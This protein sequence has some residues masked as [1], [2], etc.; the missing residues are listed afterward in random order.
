M[1]QLT[2]AEVRRHLQRAL[3]ADLIGPFDPREDGSGEEVL[4]LPP[5]RWYLTGFL[6][7]ERD[8]EAEV[9]VEGKEKEEL[10]V[11]DPTAD[12]GFASGSDEDSDD[13]EPGSEPE[14]KQKKLLPASIGFTVL[15]PPGPAG[16]TVRASVSFAEYVAE[17][18]EEEE[19]KRPKTVWRR[20]PRPVWTVDLPLD[21]RRIARGRELDGSGGVW[22]GGKLETLN[23]LG[24]STDL[25]LEPG[26]RALSLFMVNRRAPGERGRQDERFLFQ[27]RLEVEF[28]RGLVARPNRRDSGSGD[29]DEQEADLQFRER[30]EYAVGHGV[31]VEIPDQ[32]ES[33]QRARTCW[34]PCAEVPRVE[35]HE[36]PDL[37]TG[38]EQLAQLADGN[39]VRAALG[40]LPQA[41]GTWIA[42]R[43]LDELDTAARRRTRDRLMDGAE[44]ARRRI[45]AGIELLT[46]DPEVLDAFRIANRAM[47]LQARKSRPR[48]YSGDK[49]PRW[50]LFQLAFLLLSLPG[51]AG[52]DHPDRET[53]ELIFFPTGGGKTEAYLGV[54]AFLLALRRL[55]GGERPDGGLGVAV[56]LRYTL[57]LLTLDQLGRAA[58]LICAL[59]H[60]RRNGF[61]RLGDTRFAV[62]LWV[63]RGATAN[64]LTEVAQQILQ[65][66]SNPAKG[67]LSPFPLTHCP[68]CGTE[69]TRDSLTVEPSVS[70]PR[71]VVV[72]CDDFTCEYSAGRNPFGLPVLFVDEQVYRELPAFLVATVD[73]FAMLPWRGESGMLF[74]RVHTREG[75]RFSGPVDG[76]PRPGK[77]GKGAAPLPQG[78]RPPEL[79]VQDELHLISGPLGTMVGLY[80]TAIEALSTWTDAEGRRVRPKILASTAT[81]RRAREQIRALFGRERTAVFPPPGIDDS[82]TW[83]AH[84]VEGPETGRLYLG[85]AASGRAMKAIL[86]RVYVA[87][88]AAAH[89]AYDPGS[90]AKKEQAADVYMTL[91]GYFNSLREL[92]GMRRLVEDEVRTR[93]AQAEERRPLDEPDHLWFRN[94]DLKMEPAELT[95]RETT[96]KISATKARLRRVHRDEGHVDVLLASNMISVGVDIDR[97]GLMVV[98]GQPK[99]ASE[100][101]QATSRVGRQADRPG[102]VVTCFNLHRPRD[103]SHYERFA[104]FHQSFY[105][106]VEAASLTPFSGPALDRG[107]AGTLVAMTRLGEPALTPPGAVMNLGDH[108]EAAT[109]AVNRLAARAAL[110]PGLSGTDAAALAAALEGRGQGVLE[111]WE[112]LIASAREG[113]FQRSYSYFESKD[114]SL[115][116]TALDSDGASPGA[117]ELLFTAPTSMRD[118][119]PVTHLWLRPGALGRES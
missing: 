22:L 28:E 84:P 44:E 115:L 114:R 86:L 81:V 91:A 73:K 29:T 43:R 33:V 55:R 118:V 21:P 9:T 46:R 66:R 5:S 106:F 100:Y 39:A 67:A 89:R 59:D 93:C 69:L 15:L 95:S 49:R 13:A 110:Q 6:V 61:E 10:V 41:Y 50:R 70:N 77:P 51:T 102:I 107:L 12:E 74:G 40:A 83:F 38:M 35:T 34:I 94:R 96:A 79:I 68:W 97:L 64:R 82:D 8:R 92:G 36:E 32:K 63:G 42:S 30:C 72:S 57:R 75:H 16:E 24:N 65:Y 60:L 18:R 71:E 104:A 37:V 76:P 108:R 90:E 111:A 26:T 113:A 117:D 105:R 23:N 53:V 27:V 1:A 48:E 14:P 31:A 119:E 116:R 80:E 78:L 112:R 99:S 11:E 47:A 87:L 62:G 101:I 25:G 7:P 58:T 52:E 98:A 20:V 85:V 103:R 56:I 54:I 109:A 45:E 3:E 17:P 19:G 4:P 88:L 2:A